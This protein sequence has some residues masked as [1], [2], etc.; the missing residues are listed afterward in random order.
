MAKLRVGLL[1]GGRSV[2][3]EVSVTSATCILKALDPTRYDVSLV[4]IDHAGRWHLGSPALP[5]EAATSGEEVTLSAVPGQHSL[6]STSRGPSELARALRPVDVIFPIVHGQGGEDGTLQGLLELAGVPYVGAGVLGSALQMDKE[7]SKRLLAAAGIPVVPWVLIRREELRAN[8]EACASRALDALGLPVF[9]KPANLGSSVG[10]SKVKQRSELV[11]ALLEAA[12]YDRKLLVERA[13]D[14]REI[15]VA[16]LGNSPIEASV[17]GEIRTRREWYDYE[18][19]YVDED[20]E[21]LIPAPIDEAHSRA[22][23]EMAIAAVGILEGAGLA[24]VDFL[25]DRHTGELFVNEVNSLPGFTEGSM[26]P[27][28]WE[29][30]GLP[31]AALLDRL[32][33]LALERHREKVELETLYR[34]T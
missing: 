26:Y 10:I 27:R 28:L 24:R 30:S 32:I 12:R 33:E 9:V 13:V 8:P 14:A 34:R 3:H 2:E 7:A 11:P 15:E 29:A 23:R 25:M 31:Y 22:A 18:A 1:F 20:T 21:L 16:L 5:P 17:V 19:K 4:A 6:V